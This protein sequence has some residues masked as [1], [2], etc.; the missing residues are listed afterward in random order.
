MTTKNYEIKIDSASQL[1]S[2]FQGL[3]LDGSKSLT[4]AEIKEVSPLEFAG[5]HLMTQSFFPDVEDFAPVMITSKGG[6]FS[7]CYGPTARQID[8]KLHL[9]AGLVNVPIEVAKEGKK[10]AITTGKDGSTVYLEV[11][12]AEFNGYKN[13]SLVLSWEKG[14]TTVILYVSLGVKVEEG[15]TAPSTIQMNSLLLNNQLGSILLD[16]PKP[17]LP[18]VPMKYLTKGS[19][20]VVGM[21]TW[22]SKK[23]GDSVYTITVKAAPNEDGLIVAEIYEPQNPH[24]EKNPLIDVDKAPCPKVAFPAEGVNV[25]APQKMW[26]KLAEE[27]D[28]SE[29]KPGTLIIHGAK[30]AKN[31]G[32]SLD[33]GITYHEDQVFKNAK[34]IEDFDL[35]FLM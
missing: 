28:L 24:H 1:A 9:C 12:E 3:K 18:T 26:N 17:Q 16:P 21:S 32:V 7:G 30:S 5:L 15:Q 19:Y 27:P 25:F 23:T 14:D 33:C 29:D 31:G 34:K 6:A 2:H 10:T 35:S 20:Q 22:V 4:L 11:T 13:P 8:G